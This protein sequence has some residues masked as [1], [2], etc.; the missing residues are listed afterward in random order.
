MQ[1]H[2]DEEEWVQA[3]D[4]LNRQVSLF[5][6]E[7]SERDLHAKHRLSLSGVFGPVL[8]IRL[9]VGHTYSQGNR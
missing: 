3:I 1:H 9:G 2:I 7:Q 4:I 5:P 6:L 8:S